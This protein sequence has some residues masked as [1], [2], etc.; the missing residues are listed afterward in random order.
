MELHKKEVEVRTRAQGLKNIFEL[1]MDPSTTAVEVKT[2]SVAEVT[3]IEEV[4]LRFSS[5]RIGRFEEK[6]AIVKIPRQQA[7][8]LIADKS[9]KIDWL[10][11][12]VH[13]HI[14]VPR[15]YNFFE[16][17]QRGTDCKPT[18]KTDEYLKSARR[19]IRPSSAKTLPS[20]VNRH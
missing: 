10:S 9:V 6:T 5:L 4:V 15:C 20:G 14:E 19:D 3:K 7:E 2:R 13:E 17:V 8:E 11:C 1:G 16:H 12:L 18:S